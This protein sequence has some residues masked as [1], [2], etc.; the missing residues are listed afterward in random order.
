MQLGKNRVFKSTAIVCVI[1]ILCSCIS[2]VYADSDNTKSVVVSISGSDFYLT[3]TEISVSPSCASELGYTI[4]DPTSVSVFDA[5]AAAHELMFGNEYNSDTAREYLDINSGGWISKILGMDASASGFFVNGITPNDGVLNPTYGSYTSYTADKAILNQGDNVQIFFYQD[6]SFYSDYYARFDK[7]SIEAKVGEEFKL[8]LS[9]FMT[10]MGTY[11]AE[12]LEASVE[13]ISD[14]TILTGTD[15]NNLEATEIVTDDNG[16]FTLSFDTDGTYYISALSYSDDFTYFV[17]PWCI[18]VIGDTVLSTESPSFSPSAEPSVSPSP[19]VSA[20]PV[21]TDKR[22]QLLKSE[23]AKTYYDSTESWQIFDMVCGGY[24][25]KLRLKSESIAKLTD[26]AYSA[27]SASDAVRCGLALLSLSADLTSLR[28]SDAAEY[29]LL[30]R[31]SEYSK[32][33]L[34]YV[35]NAIMALALYHTADY[36]PTSGLTECDLIDYILDSRNALGVWGYS[37]DGVDF[38]DYDSTA[39]VLNAF[40]PYYLSKTADEAKIPQSIY[41]EIINT[42]NTAVTVLS[43]LQ[44]S[45]GSLGNAN[46]DAAAIAGLAAIGINPKADERFIKD[47]NSLING[48]LSYA[49]DDNSGFGYTNNTEYNALATEQ[50]FRALIAQ[51]GLSSSENGIYNIYDINPIEPS[52]NSGSGSSSGGNSGGSTGGSSVITVS[53]IVKGDTAHGENEHSGSYPIWIPSAKKTMKSGSTVGEL[54]KSVLAESGYIVVGID[55]GYIKS[56]TSPDGITIGEK[57][58][59]KNSGWLYKVNGKSPSVGISDY[60]LKSGDIVELYYT[61]DYT[62]DSSSNSS[63]TSSGGSGAAATPEPSAVPTQTLAPEPIKTPYVLY[64]DVSNEYWAYEYIKSLTDN[65][66]LNGDDD[67]FF[68]PDDSITR[69][70]FTAM[71]TRLCGGSAGG[72]TSEFLDVGADEWYS[73]Y[74]AWAAQNGIVSGVGNN[75]FEPNSAIT[76]ED[77]CVMI[78]RS[79]EFKKIKKADAREI[80]KYADDLEISDY[81]RE[82]VY[83]LAIEGVINGYEDGTFKPKQNAARSEASKIAACGILNI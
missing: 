82:F 39:M 24:S 28:T 9:G 37:W 7:T 43:D 8:N 45:N 55:S 49:L 19:T 3:P 4:D 15:P 47:G 74:I 1:A 10:F 33:D 58:N 31:I 75:R 12:Q 81:S 78:V 68:R 21:D 77:M 83:T 20:E 36:T 57:T 54:I 23:I 52:N 25:S 80:D 17:L 14:I 44:L 69:A 61:D 41:D 59:E 46:T 70:E 56:I 32:D 38:V 16:D 51:L 40:A 79:R 42:V 76:R 66:I 71:I 13:P 2:F 50:G 26:E 67:G 27:A 65:G 60:K 48:I 53:C 11:P 6:K 22:I 72:L 30:E 73:G 18:A 62:K 35:T 29:N 63:G 5:M 64:N 34:G